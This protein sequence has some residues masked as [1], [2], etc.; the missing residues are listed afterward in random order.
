LIKY[1][2]CISILFSGVLFSEVVTEEVIAE[3][4]GESVEIA[5]DR[6]LASAVSQVNGVSINSTIVNF[7]AEAQITTTDKSPVSSKKTKIEDIYAK[8]YQQEI[9]KKTNG[10]IERFEIISSEMVKENLFRVK[11]K[12]FVP[13][14]KLEQ[15]AMRKKIAVLGFTPRQKCCYVNSAKLNEN[16]FNE[17]LTSSVS[18]YLVQTKKFTVLDRNYEDYTNLEQARLK[19]PDTSIRELAKVGQ[20]LVSD[21]VVV[22][23]INNISLLE[24]TRNLKTVDRSIT[25]VH[26]NASINMR[27]INVATTQII[28]SKVFSIDL[29]RKFKEIDNVVETTLELIAILADNIGKRILNEIFPIRVESI[30]GSDL[31][32]GSGGDIL[33]VGELYNLVELGD[34][35]IDSYTGE[36]LGKIEKVIGT[37]RITQVDSGLSYAEIVKLDDESIRLGFFKNKFLIKPI[38]QDSADKVIIKEDSLREEIE[39]SFEENW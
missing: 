37:V 31:I 15:S 38:I 33:S 23:T 7:T 39:E 22:G 29:D 6:A 19:S 25:T 9:I 8:G 10:A 4:E 13:K 18:S 34:E 28:Y 35:I 3:G 12:V 1:Y 36:S 17:E 20:E 11:L 30:S 24:K 5:L 2:F 27:I 26:G 32:L 21:F 16:T 14:Y